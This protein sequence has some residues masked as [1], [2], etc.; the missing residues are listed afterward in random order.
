MAASPAKRTRVIAITLAA[1]GLAA[2]KDSGLPGR[3]TPIA[4]AAAAEWRYPLY[5]PVD[6]AA[7]FEL[8]G[9]RWIPRHT[10]LVIPQHMLRPVAATGRGQVHAL[11]WDRQPYTRLFLAAP[12]GEWTPVERI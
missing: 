10:T 12:G 5:Q 6:A 1:V 3:N 4:E 7:T 2:C 9:Q 8:D 11:V